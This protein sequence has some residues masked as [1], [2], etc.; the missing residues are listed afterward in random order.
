MKDKVQSKN[1]I[2]YEIKRFFVQTFRL[3][4]RWEYSEF[5]TRGIRKSR[6]EY[7][8][9]YPWVYMRLFAMLFVLFAVFL[10]IIRF[11]SN[12]LFAPTVMFLSAIVFNLSFLVFLYEL[13][14]KNDLS[15]LTVVAA[16]LIGGTLSDVIAQI[17]YSIFS[18]PNAWLSAVYTGFFEELAKAGATILVIVAIRNKSPLAGFL[19]GAAVGCGFSIVEDLGYIFI[20]SNDLSAVN[21]TTTVNLF[22]TRGLSAFCTHTLWTAMVGWAY[23]Y[24]NR[25]F[26]NACFY[27]ML[28]LSCGLHICWDLPLT[29]FLY[30][31]TIT[32]CVIAAAVTCILILYYSRKKIFN[33]AKRQEEESSPPQLNEVAISAD[34]AFVEAYSGGNSQTEENSEQDNSQI[35]VPRTYENVVHRGHLALTFCA[36]LMAVIAII[37]CAIPFRETYYTQEFTSPQSFAYFMQ[38]GRQLVINKDR[39]FDKTLPAD[40]NAETY[41][42]GELTKVTQEV[43][44]GGYTYYYAYNVVTINDVVYYYFTD[45]SV[46]IIDNGEYIYTAEDIYNNGKL[47]VSYFRIRGDMT[48]YYFNSSGNITAFIYDAS[49][50]RDLSQPQYS[51]LFYT[52]AGLAG[53]AVCIYVVFTIKARRI[54]KNVKG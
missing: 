54:K 8:G 52:F 7:N 22:I 10:L 45:E 9:Q 2:I 47:Y 44:E 49:F 1:R 25:H 30:Y 43:E 29:G 51:A 23:A 46:K 37:Y 20:Y 26:S 13:Y 12:E 11:T 50:V 16:M 33:E 34:T 4:N 28:I 39:Q 31:L 38:D 19:M 48:G 15:F 41:V 40:K 18:A 6:R 17:L 27:L 36:F 32:L 14:P 53:V 42:S 5:V 24:F 35:I 3:H 21:I